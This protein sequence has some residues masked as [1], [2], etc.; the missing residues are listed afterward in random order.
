[1]RT[2]MMLKSRY[3]VWCA[4]LAVAASTVALGQG[5]NAAADNQNPKEREAKLIAVLQSDAP[6]A[7]KAITCKRLAVYGTKDAVPALAPLLLDKELSSW[8]RI[9]LE[10]IPGPAADEALRSALGKAQ[11]RLLIGVINSIAVRRDAQAVE[12]AG[13]EAQGQ[14][15]GGG[16]GGGR[17]LGPHRGRAGGPDS[18][19]SPW[20][21][22]R[23]SF[24]RPW[25]KAAFCA[26][27]G[28]W[29]KG[30]PPMP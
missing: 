23:P 2:I 11:G 8:A 22:C 17:G 7:E 27:R 12:R 20:P 24:V 18:G 28:L 16:L 6:P 4:V 9:A 30:N 21:N 3:L 15:R 1:M 14:R 29:R 5:G 19:T 13:G 26:R 25:P 10:A